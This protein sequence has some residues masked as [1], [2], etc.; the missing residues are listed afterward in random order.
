MFEW[1]L[2]KKKSAYYARGLS[3]LTYIQKFSS[4][5]FLQVF[6]RLGK[7]GFESRNLNIGKQLLKFNFRKNTLRSYNMILQFIFETKV[8]AQKI[9]L[10][11]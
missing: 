10:N 6:S 2:W 1:V 3:G 4:K 5:Q 8:I 11:I 7:N 9:L